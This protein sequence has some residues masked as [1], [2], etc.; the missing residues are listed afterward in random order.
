[1]RR[2]VPPTQ[3]ASGHP[4]LVCAFLNC[5]PKHNMTGSSSQVFFPHL[6]MSSSEAAGVSGESASLR[7]VTMHAAPLATCHISGG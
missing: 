3:Y 2:I 6:L 4:E 7:T 5:G 1:M